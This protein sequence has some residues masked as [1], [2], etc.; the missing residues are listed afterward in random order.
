M[1][2]QTAVLGEKKCC[3]LLEIYFSTDAE[4]GGMYSNT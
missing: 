1:R 2:K 4:V 3:Y